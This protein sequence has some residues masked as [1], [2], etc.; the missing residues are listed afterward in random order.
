MLRRRRPLLRAAAVGG[1]AYAVGRRGGR[2]REQAQSAEDEQNQR[3]ADLEQQQQPPPQAAPPA[4][5]A[6]AGPGSGAVHDRPAQPAQ[7]TASAGRAERR[8]VRRGQG[9]AARRLNRG[10]RLSP[11]HPGS[12]RGTGTGTTTPG[13]CTTPTPTG[14]NCTAW[15]P[16]TRARCA[17]WSIC[18]SPRPAPTVPSRW[19]TGPAGGTQHTPAAAH[20]P[21]RSLH[22]QPGHGGHP[23]APGG[24]HP[25]PSHRGAGGHPRPWRAGRAV[26]SRGQRVVVDAS[27]TPYV[28]LER[29]AAAMP[30]AS[31]RRQRCGEAG[32][33]GRTQ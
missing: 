20:Q 24:E 21:A 11:G 22:L 28:D 15:P 8:G 3:I 7:R 6:R 16:S 13:S 33:T 17:S 23:R 14:P 12:G 1:T 4:A 9:Q 25:R 18:G 31:S 27:G 26:R 19:T 32:K 5:S 30:P 2:Q 10:A 29:Q